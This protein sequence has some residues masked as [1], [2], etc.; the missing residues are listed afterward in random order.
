MM[1]KSIST[2]MFIA[3]IISFSLP[4]NSQESKS[5]G[6]SKVQGLMFDLGY[7]PSKLSAAV[8][9][10]WWMFSAS[11][12]IAGFAND[13]PNYARTSPTGVIIS[14]NQPLPSG[15]EADR[16]TSIDVF[17]DLGFH[18]DFYPFSAFAMLGFYNA[19]DSILAKNIETGSRFR[20]ATETKSGMSFGLG[21][22]YIYSDNITIGAGYHTRRGIFARFTYTWF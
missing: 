22:E 8:G 5:A 7:G 20:Y 14:P 16:Y 4:L 15:Y 3:I 1:K 10:R 13:L 18:Y 11:L 6:S 19:Q 21:G 9:Y 17:G 2:I 12:G